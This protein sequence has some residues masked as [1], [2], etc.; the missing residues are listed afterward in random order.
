V[1]VEAKGFRSV[2]LPVTL[3]VSVTSPG[4][5]KLEVGEA[6]QVVEVQASTVQVN[7]EQTTVQGVVTTQQ[8]EQLPNKPQLPRSGAIGARDSD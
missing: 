6:S 1:R 7:T 8:I 4:N 3:Q 5:V 2:E